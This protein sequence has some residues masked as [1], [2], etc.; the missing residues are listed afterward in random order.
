M[1]LLMHARQRSD[2]GR[3]DGKNG[4]CRTGLPL[5][6]AGRRYRAELQVPGDSVC[7]L[8]VLLLG[9]RE[10]RFRFRRLV[11]KLRLGCE[12]DVG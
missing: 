7:R 4:H 8:L 11:Q 3:H 5:Q 10:D 9:L 2:L 6:H 12:D 1:P